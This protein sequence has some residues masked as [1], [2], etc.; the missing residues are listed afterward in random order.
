MLETVHSRNIK[1]DMR[2]FFLKGTKQ[3]Y[4][5]QGAKKLFC[6]NYIFAVLF[7]KYKE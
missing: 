5:S 7:V 3:S 1:L 4:V 2:C 6:K